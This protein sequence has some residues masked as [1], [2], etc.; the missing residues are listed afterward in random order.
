MSNP[1]YFFFCFN[2]HVDERI[3]WLVNEKKGNTQRKRAKVSKRVSDSIEQ[4]I[5][6]CEKKSF[7]EKMVGRLINSECVDT[8]FSPVQVI[9]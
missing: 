1:Q 2:I 4:R 5:F 8:R 6:S 7:K 3:V 9:E